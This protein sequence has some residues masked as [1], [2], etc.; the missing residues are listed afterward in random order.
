MP[1]HDWTR[2][3]AGIFHAF[4]QRWIG[5]I[6]DVL[7]E[8]LLPEDY[9][10]LPEQWAAGRIPDVLTLRGRGG[11]GAPEN[12]NGRSRSTMVRERP[13][14]T[15]VVETATEAYSRKKNRAV[16]RHVSD[17][18][19][20]AVIEVVSPGNKSGRIAF[21]EFTSKVLELLRSQ[22]NVLLID[23]LPRSRRDPRGI[24]AAIWEL[25]TDERLAV[26]RK[27]PLTLVSYETGDTTRGYVEPVAVGQSLPDMPLF[28]EFGWHVQLPL[29]ATYAAA[30]RSV[31][32]RWRRVI[33][34]SPR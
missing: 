30:Y 18:R 17:D 28:L 29:E 20:V 9:Y 24:H 27:L 25:V 21:Q 14:T 6:C 16:V 10:A 26:P 34:G 12:P 8:D 31:P 2:V 23:L 4:H 19:I 5:A 33:E 11:N 15:Y 7:N 1:I 32:R 22:V 3:D 13:R